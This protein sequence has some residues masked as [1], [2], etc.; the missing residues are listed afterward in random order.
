MQSKGC[1][2]QAP[3]EDDLD[4]TDLDKIDHL[5]TDLQPD[6]MINTAAYTRSTKRKRMRPWRLK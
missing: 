6:L 5:I 4:I 2:V 1:P 3:P